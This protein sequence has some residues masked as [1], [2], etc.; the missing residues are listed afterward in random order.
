DLHAQGFLT[1]EAEAG[2]AAGERV[3][4]GVP[5]EVEASLGS[6]RGSGGAASS[7]AARADPDGDERLL[8]QPARKAPEAAHGDAPPDDTAAGD[9]TDA[10]TVEAGAETG[11]AT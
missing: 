5:V 10:A 8:P 9:A 7:G 1:D 11:G 6:R 3:V 2:D 4:A